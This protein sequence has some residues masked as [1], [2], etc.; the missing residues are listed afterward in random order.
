MKY[1]DLLVKLKLL[2]ILNL[3]IFVQF[4]VN[5]QE[6]KYRP[7]SSKEV[8]EQFELGKKALGKDDY[9]MA[10]THFDA[11]IRE[12]PYF[13]DAY[14][15]RAMAK[16]SLDDL[17]GA[18]LDYNILLHMQPD[19]REALFSRG[20]LR[21]KQEQYEYALPD[22]ENLLELPTGETQAVFFQ[23][24]SSNSGIG[25]IS[26][27][28]TMQA[29]IQNYLGLTNTK[30]ERYPQAIAHFNKAININNRNPDYLV[31]RGMAKEGIRDFNGAED[32]Y[33][34]A[35]QLNPDHSLAKYN[36]SLI[37]GE[38]L[39]GFESIDFYSDIIDSDP[40]FHQAY[41]Q[42]GLAKFNLND[43]QGALSDFNKALSLEPD[44]IVALFNRG[45]TREK[46]NELETAKQDFTSVLSL[47]PNHERA[48]LSRA[49]ISVKFKAYQEAIHD[50]DQAIDRNPTYA[51]AFYNR[52]V[53]KFNL[54]Q[55]TEACL[56][57]SMALKLGMTNAAETYKRMCQ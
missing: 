36:L 9:V 25:S 38:S 30:L 50:Y 8:Q 49:N 19:L 39:S 10:I 31:N 11:C 37:A 26:T 29:E 27:M 2:V 20:V 3:V 47:D 56:D 12:D 44:N 53:A 35:I 14:F 1:N 55:K 5:A 24:S 32:D 16:E 4:S 17:E 48:L 54:K 43:M 6:N 23:L 42:R 21:Y 52:G 33:Q 41:V 46:L 28:E 13:K 34:K 51:L 22:F 7:L 18:L 45:L 15:S 40:S 57:M